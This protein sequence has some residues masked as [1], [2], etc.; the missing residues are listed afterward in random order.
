MSV[1]ET[2]LAQHPAAPIAVVGEGPQAI[3]QVRYPQATLW[4]C[5]TPWE[6]GRKGVACRSTN[7]V[8]AAVAA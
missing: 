2:F 8:P 3:W 6:I 1:L 5:M 4:V 7:C